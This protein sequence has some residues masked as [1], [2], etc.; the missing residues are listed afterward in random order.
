MSQRL[1]YDLEDCSEFSQTI[2]ARAPALIHVSAALL[3]LFLLAAIVWSSATKADLVIKAPGRIRSIDEPTKVFTASDT[4]LMGAVSEVGFE[5]GDKVAKGDVLVRLDSQMLDNQIAKLT[6]T[7]DA[8][9]A[10]LVRLDQMDLLLD[11]QN[12]VA[13]AKAQAELEKA[14]E[15]IRTERS[16]R[17]STMEAAQAELDAATDRYTRSQRLKERR[18]ISEVELV[19][20]AAKLKQARQKMRQ[21]ELPVE[22]AQIEILSRAIELVQRD[23][24]VKKEEL[25]A[26]RIVKHG[27]IESAQEEL[28]NLQI[29]RTHCEIR[30]PMDGVIVAGQVDVGDVLGAGTSIAE[31]SPSGG[32]RFEAAVPSGDVGDLHT[33]M[34]ANIKFDAFDYQRYGALEG[35][36]MY[37]SPDSQVIEQQS[38][39]PKQVAYV[40]RITVEDEQIGRGDRIGE[41]K[42]GLGGVAEIV[43]KQESLLALFVKKIRHTVSLG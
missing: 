43:V 3:S 24:A 35:E 6:H 38:D 5:M 33:G 28:A 29:K 7:I 39:M 13:K 11:Q 10:E 20:V 23:H 22:T 34:T 32:F 9:K 31:I 40:V 36:V 21:A 41:L 12:H 26:R 2:Q 30:A 25:A 15:A 42:L 1:I 8:A 27:E 18:A 14:E 19:E 16:R 17:E 37:V 4:Q